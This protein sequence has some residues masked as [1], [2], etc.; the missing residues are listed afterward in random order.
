MMERYERLDIE[1]TV[2]V[3]RKLRDTLRANPARRFAARFAGTI[4]AALLQGA[5]LGRCPD[6]VVGGIGQVQQA[7]AARIVADPL[8]EVVQAGPIAT[9]LTVAVAEGCDLLEKAGLGGFAS[10][11]AARQSQ[12]AFYERNTLKGAQLDA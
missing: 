8:V 9:R 12:C 7:P 6:R 3:S 1:M 4:V 2:P 11:D 10:P 5:A